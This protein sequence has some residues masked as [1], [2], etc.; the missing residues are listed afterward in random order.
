MSL[1]AAFLN[2][3]GQPAVVAGGGRGALRRTQTLLEAGLQVTVVAP[4][5]HPEFSVLPVTVV[6]RSCE[7]ADLKDAQVV[8]AATN[9]PAVNDRLCA[10]AHQQGALV[11]HAGDAA[12][13]TLRFPAVI[14]SGDLQVA[15]STGRELPMLAQALGERI[16]ALLPDSTTVE[17]WSRQREEALR[18]T[19]PGRELA[20]QTL[21]KDI[22]TTMGVPA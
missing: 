11:N 17:Q 7:P 15:V 3:S 19:G 21:R 13:S 2:L 10:A 6:Q 20:L 4:Q 18:E 9:D 12:L 8:V 14:S 22:R 5:V 16:S 1:L